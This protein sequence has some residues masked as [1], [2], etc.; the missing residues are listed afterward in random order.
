M[1][2]AS[3]TVDSIGTATAPLATELRL[4]PGQ[5]AVVNPLVPG[6]APQRLDGNFDNESGTSIAVTDVTVSIGRVSKGSLDPASCCDSHDFTLADPIM[7]VGHG[8][9]TGLGVD[10]WGGATLAFNHSLA[11][12][13]ACKG[14]TVHPSYVVSV[15]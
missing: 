14:A 10:A 11:N 9:A 2:N 4:T 8:V 7:A 13:D 5:T 3:W 1:A 15:D 6:G 12:Q